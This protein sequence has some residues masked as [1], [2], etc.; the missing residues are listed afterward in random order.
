[1]K[2]K[3][4][5]LL[6]ILLALTLMFGLAASALADDTG[7]D[8]GTGGG[9]FIP[10]DSEEPDDPGDPD[11]PGGS[12]DPQW[13]TWDNTTSVTLQVTFLPGTGYTLE[14][15]PGT[16]GRTDGSVVVTL[17]A[18]QISSNRIPD[19]I[20]DDQYYQINGWAILNQQGQ[21][22]EIDLASYNFT[23]SNTDVYAI[24]EDV[25]PVYT[26]MSP[27]RDNWYYQY[28]R[29]L[30]V[31]GVMDGYPGYVFSPEGNVTWGEALK[32]ILLAVGYPEQAPTDSHWASGYL[33]VAQRDN[34]LAGAVVTDLNEPITRLEYGRVAAL[35]L[36]FTESDTKT[37]F[38]DTED[39][40]ILALYD[41]GIMEGS[42]DD[43]GDRM[44]MPDANIRRSEISTVIWRINNYRAQ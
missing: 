17:G 36:G 44:Y 41:A 26:D 3:L 5:S 33:A 37:P 14:A 29:D 25:W 18:S 28:V 15:Q 16:S 6:S 39:G 23:R 2:S 4:R 30:S 35:A 19:V 38:A 21:L 9:G 20:P 42:V 12:G 43:N 34:L 7:F 31:A 27:N 13:P 40:L 10:D 8:P 22:E 24:C 32:L 11:D 1:M